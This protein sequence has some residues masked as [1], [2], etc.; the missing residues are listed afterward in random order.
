MN[1]N[2]IKK[3]INITTIIKTLGILQIGLVTKFLN[4]RKHL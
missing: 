3:L 4:Y 2:T 1:N